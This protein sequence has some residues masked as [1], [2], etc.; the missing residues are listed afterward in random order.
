M[1]RVLSVLASWARTVPPL[2]AELLHHTGF[3]ATGVVR[4]IGQTSRSPTQAVGS[5]R[6]RVPPSH[7]A[8]MLYFPRRATG[9]TFCRTFLRANDAQV[10]LLGTVGIN[11]PIRG[12][13]M[14]LNYAWSDD[15]DEWKGLPA[16][17]A[18]E[19]LEVLYD[20]NN[21]HLTK[22]EILAAARATNS[23]IHKFFTWDEN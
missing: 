4:G 9:V 1:R 22:E 11:H 19:Y 21:G 23:P 5:Y 17:R 6:P 15:R 16:Q 8:R 10:Y 7:D 13:C 14:G 3:Y 2:W 18:G 12:V 20:R